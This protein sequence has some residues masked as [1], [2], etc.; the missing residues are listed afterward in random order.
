MST[1]N[2]G[3]GPTPPRAA[4]P[5]TARPVQAFGRVFVANPGKERKRRSLFVATG[6]HLVLIGAGLI[7]SFTALTV[8]NDPEHVDFTLN[9]FEPPKPPD[10]A[11]PKP[12]AQQRYEIPEQKTEPEPEKP[13]PVEEKRVE[14]KPQLQEPEIEIPQTKEQRQKLD[15]ATQKLETLA[16]RMDAPEVSASGARTQ[17]RAAASLSAASYHE[18]FSAAMD[19]P[20]V[21]IPGGGRGGPGLPARAPGIQVREG[22]GGGSIVAYKSDVP[23]TMTDFTV[24]APGPSGKRGGKPGGMAPGII[25]VEGNGVGGGAGSGGRGLK[26]GDGPA[27]APGGEIGGFGVTGRPGRGTG[28]RIEGVR[29]ALANKYGLPLVS[30]NDLGQRSTEAARWNLLL[31][32]L[33]ELVRRAVSERRGGSGGEVAAVEIDG[34]NVIIRYRDGIVHV[35]VPTDDGLTALY[36]ARAAGARQVTSKVQEAESAISALSRITRGAS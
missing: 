18:T 27:D 28:A 13:Q 20:E 21:K 30:V 3:G 24:G 25:T 33:S 19:A 23:A 31:P 7:A 16:G 15:L 2:Q 1:I 12:K 36:V 5:V 32:Q 17:A 22:G 10:V 34:S 29:A 8:I 11:P 35:L 26:Y 9:F 4:P 14:F 6:A